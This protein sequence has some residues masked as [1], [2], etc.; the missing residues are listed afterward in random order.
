[1]WALWFSV[2][3]HFSITLYCYRC[4]VF[5]VLCIQRS[6]HHL[7]SLAVVHCLVN[8]AFSCW[9]VWDCI[10]P[11]S[12]AIIH[13]DSLGVV[14][15][16]HVCSHVGSFY[17]PV[18]FIQV[19]FLYFNGF[20]YYYYYCYYYFSLVYFDWPQ[21]WCHPTGVGLLANRRVVLGT[22][23]PHATNIVN[24]PLQ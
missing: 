5:L 1:M 14:I 13:R 23:P 20:H 16:L 9:F 10:P 18:I 3:L 6:T 2:A 15:V 11:R 17:W 22:S 21:E 4:V 24:I 7:C 12:P 8:G 19:S